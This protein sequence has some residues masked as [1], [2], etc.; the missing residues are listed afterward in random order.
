MLTNITLENFK[1]FQKL[2]NLK[3]KP[4]TIL[5][6]TNS[7]GKSSILQSIL[8]L[9]QTLESKNSNQNLVLNGDFVKLPYFK[10]VIY[11]KDLSNPISFDFEF[12][13]KPNMQD[14]RQGKRLPIKYLLMDLINNITRTNN[15]SEYI[16]GYKVSLKTINGQNS[17]KNEYLNSLDVSHLCVKISEIINKET[18]PGIVISVNHIEDDLYDISWSNLK[19]RFR[20]HKEEEHENGSMKMRMQFENLLPIAFR[21]EN[22]D[23]QKENNF[24][25][26]RL[27]L[28]RMKDLLQYF[29]SM[30]SYVGPLRKSHNEGGG[31]YFGDNIV[32][33][34]NKGEN[35][36]FLYL[37]E[38]KKSLKN[39]YFYNKKD[40]TFTLNQSISL[41]KAFDEWFGLMGIEGFGGTETKRIIS[42]SLNANKFDKTQ[43]DISQ[44]GFGVSQMFPIVLEGLR[45]EKGCTLLLEQPEIHLHPNL[46]MQIADYFISLAL[47]EKRVIVETH[48]DH[49][50]NRLVRRIVEDET[51]NL[52]NLI[53]IYFIK[54]S[55]NGSTFE[56]IN[57]D[58]TK[59]ITNWPS[60]FFDQTANEQMRIM[61]AG[62]KKRKNLRNKNKE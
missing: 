62:L 30:Y 35:A 14:V 25:N 60:D 34:G 45:M 54:P 1:A 53:G 28:Y 58:D 52:T 33:I 22:I 13:V 4:I 42:L 16:I 23:E 12:S 55:I 40:D 61:Q 32:N 29:F 38:K 46:Q 11:K 6:G 43:I 36:P 17:D 7:C 10:D 48:S 27:A 50:I 41:E 24:Q 5:C 44:V 21:P 47:S 15:D 51:L 59:G 19:N 31:S 20:S 8:L 3:V 49:I 9:K 57:I 39:H 56:E 26:I 2:D 37:K 18:K